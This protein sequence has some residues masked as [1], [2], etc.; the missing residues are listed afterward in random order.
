MDILNATLH[1]E[2]SVICKG[3]N[4]FV[5]KKLLHN[6]QRIT[7]NVWRTASVAQNLLVDLCQV[8]S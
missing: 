6:V 7:G 8:V 1:S 5:C 3:H 2:A 4:M